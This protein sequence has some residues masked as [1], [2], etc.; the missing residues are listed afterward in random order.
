ML[1]FDCLRVEINDE[2]IIKFCGVSKLQLSFLHSG[3]VLWF[4][5]C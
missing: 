4:I 2:L 1:I 3:H 5:T